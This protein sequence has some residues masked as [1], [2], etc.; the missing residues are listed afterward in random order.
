MRIIIE[1]NYKVKEY[2]NVSKCENKKDTVVIF[3]EDAEHKHPGAD[4]KEVYN[5]NNLKFSCDGT[6]R[7]RNVPINCIIS[8]ID[9]LHIEYN[10]TS[11]TISCPNH[12]II[13]AK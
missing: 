13:E 11:E 1:D 9:G 7:D 12:K 8:L 4:I 2:E 10:E 5:C 6:I 3:K